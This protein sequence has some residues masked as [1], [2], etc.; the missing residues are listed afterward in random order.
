[1]SA[2]ERAYFPERLAAHNPRPRSRNPS[3]HR[4]PVRIRVQL[5]PSLVP[6]ERR[7]AVLSRQLLEKLL[8]EAELCAQRWRAVAIVLGLVLLCLLFLW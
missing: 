2:F 5:P 7:H 3:P 4:V 6:A 1:M 8:K